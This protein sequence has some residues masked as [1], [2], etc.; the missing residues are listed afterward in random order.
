[1][2][3]AFFI[4]SIGAGVLNACVRSSGDDSRVV[5]AATLFP[6]AAI[7]FAW[8]RAD[9][10]HRGIRPPTGAPLLVGLVALVGVPYY[11]YRILPPGKATLRVLAAIGIFILSAMSTALSDWIAGFLISI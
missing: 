2:L 8:C 10:K 7:L 3:C 6:Y 1:M 11:F 9:A 4:V 5:T